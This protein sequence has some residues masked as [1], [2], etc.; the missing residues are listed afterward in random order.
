[1]ITRVYRPRRGE[2]FA[3][4]W[5]PYEPGEDSPQ[6]PRPTTTPAPVDGHVRVGV[7]LTATR[8]GARRAARRML[9][10]YEQGLEPDRVDPSEMEIEILA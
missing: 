5:R 9:A 6:F 4:L 1:M 3:E 10:R 2:W 8:W 7:K